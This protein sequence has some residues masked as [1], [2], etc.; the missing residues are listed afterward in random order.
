MILR[1][2]ILLGLAGAATIGAGIVHL[3]ALFSPPAAPSE[4]V[5]IDFPTLTAKVK[6]NLDEGKATDREERVLA[7]ATT[8]W[9]RN[10]LRER[11][12]IIDDKIDPVS[13]SAEYVVPL[14]KYVGFLSIGDKV[15]AIIDG[16]NYIPGE[17]IEGGE[18]TLSQIYPNHIEL[19]RRGANDSV[20]VRLEKPD[21]AES[22]QRTKTLQTTRPLEIKPPPG[23][24][25]PQIIE[26]SEIT[27]DR[28]E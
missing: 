3:P 15:I 26:P 14:P 17:A 9:P 21:G 11:P 6:V 28:N 22:P 19:I 13:P 10:P 12:L 24:T 8:E 2:K 18:F 20:N 5:S 16:Q 27:G 25:V 7:A 4:R 23:I 1:E